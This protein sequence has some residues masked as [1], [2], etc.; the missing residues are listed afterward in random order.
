MKSVTCNK[1]GWVWMEVSRDH[2]ENEVR[3]F[4]LYFDGLSKK[5]QDDYYGGNKSSIKHY[6]GCHCGNSYKNF[7]DFKPGD[8]P[9][10]CTISPIID[11]NE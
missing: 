11:R 6:D 10:G 5:E 8:C 1:C 7:R 9:D 2:A 3:K 4:N